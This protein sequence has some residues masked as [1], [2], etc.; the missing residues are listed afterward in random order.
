M[1]ERMKLPGYSNRYESLEAM[2][3]IGGR[4]DDQ[5]EIKFPQIKGECYIKSI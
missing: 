5:M 4:T 2:V 1:F 3:K